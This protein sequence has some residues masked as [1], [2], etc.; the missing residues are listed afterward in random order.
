MVWCRVHHD[1]LSSG[2]VGVVKFIEPGAVVIDLV[3]DPPQS[4]HKPIGV[5]HLSDASLAWDLHDRSSTNGGGD[6]L[7]PRVR[8]GI[9]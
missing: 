1:L 6:F 8:V 7:S 2:Q 4:I 5:T 3:Q 9:S